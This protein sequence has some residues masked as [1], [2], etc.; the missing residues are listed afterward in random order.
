[1]A[2]NKSNTNSSDEI[3]L[4]QMFQLIGKGFDWIFYGLLRLFLFLKKNLIKLLGLAII[5]AALGYG[6]NQIIS[7]KLK[8]EVIVKP[9]LESKNYLYD[10]VDEIQANILAENT[11]FFSSI[12]FNISNF[13]GLE[14]SIAPVDEKSKNKEEDIR[15]LELLQNFE[16]TDAISDILRA[17]LQNNTSY[18]HR[19]TFFYKDTETGKEFAE[20]VLDYINTN[21]YFE[22][23]IGAYRE[24]ARNRIDENKG[25]LT[26]ID[27]IINNYSKKMVQ[28]D[29]LMGTEKIVLDNQERI[30]ITGLFSLK[31]ELIRD[32]ESKKIELQER[33]DAI[34]VISFGKPQEVVRSFF[35]KKIVLL[36]AILIGMFL[37]F[38]IVRYLNR[39]AIEM[40]IS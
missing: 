4:G 32:I 9:N 35:G 29:V 19:I 2:D 28:E 13:K 16:N 39:K 5:G 14:I 30:N 12:G 21:D 31:N 8:T 3:D 20:K 11:E 7:K 37:M 25:L 27:E 10:V 26:Q 1:M 24:N 33:T 17:E 36:P 40:E 23:L 15:Y 34:K 38:S 22:G 18:N 6:L